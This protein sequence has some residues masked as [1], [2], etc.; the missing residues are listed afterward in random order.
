MSKMLSTECCD[1]IFD[2]AEIIGNTDPNKFNMAYFRGEIHRSLS[3]APINM[4]PPTH[5]VENECETVCCVIGTLP[6]SGVEKFRIAASDH[7]KAGRFDYDIYCERLFPGVGDDSIQRD[8]FRETFLWRLMFS[9]YWA[10]CCGS[11]TQ[12]AARMRFVANWHGTLDELK[13]E[14]REIYGESFIVSPQ[15]EEIQM[16]CEDYLRHKVDVAQI[17]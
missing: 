7:D 16:F 11:P 12:A 3:S 1:N 8:D 13:D 14:L 9:S 15:K 4:P 17:A 6:G 2:A 5:A 10:K